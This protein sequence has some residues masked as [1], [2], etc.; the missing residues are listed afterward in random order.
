MP[1]NI[2]ETLIA[3]GDLIELVLLPARSYYG[4]MYCFG[5]PRL[6]CRQEAYNL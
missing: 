4:I 3:V 5:K 1:D 6:L 2:S